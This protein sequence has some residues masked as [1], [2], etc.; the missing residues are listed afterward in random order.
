MDTLIV[1]QRFNKLKFV[2]KDEVERMVQSGESDLAARG[3]SQL[4]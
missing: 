3:E 2:G 4:L 1:A